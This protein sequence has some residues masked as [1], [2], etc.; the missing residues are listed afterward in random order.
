MRDALSLLDQLAPAY[1]ASPTY[2]S[3]AEAVGTHERATI[4]AMTRAFVLRVAATL[5]RAV[6]EVFHRG[7]DLKRLAEELA[8]ELRHLTGTG[9]IWDPSV[10]LSWADRGPPI[11]R[12]Q[13][14][15]LFEV[16]SSHEDQTPLLVG[17]TFG[18][19]QVMGGPEPIQ[20][21]SIAGSLQSEFS[22][23]KL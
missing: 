14:P 23:S 7:L 22:L 2:V 17:L 21:F 11:L 6:D 5:L 18:Y 16:I 12:A 3:T 10:S 19:A 1:G 8:L 4:V 9:L 15:L 20:A 13:V